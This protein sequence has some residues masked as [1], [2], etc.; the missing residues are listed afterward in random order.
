MGGK[1]GLNRKWVSSHSYDSRISTKCSYRVRRETAKERVMI[2]FKG[3][4]LRIEALALSLQ[5]SFSDR[6]RNN[7]RVLFDR[8][9][10]LSCSSKTDSNQKDDAVN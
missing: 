1:I 10:M 6:G 3:F 7:V 4:I 8:N 9:Q 2:S 5:Q